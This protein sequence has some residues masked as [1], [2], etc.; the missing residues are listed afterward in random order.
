MAAR[1]LLAVVLALTATACTVS[2]SG[3]A[4]RPLTAVATTSAWGSILAQLGGDKVRTLS[5]ISNP[6]ADPHDYEPTPADARALA[7][8]RL[9]VENGVGYDAWA[10]RVLDA[11]PDSE[12]VVLNVGTLSGVNDDEN[13]HLWYSPADVDKLAG[14]VSDALV[15]IDPSEGDYFA[16]RR[17]AF[18]RQ[19]LARYHDLIADIRDRYA[20]VPI[21][22][23]ES[24]VSPLAN[25]LGLDLI[26]PHDFLTAI[27]EGIDPAAVDKRAVD[28]QIRDHRIKVYVFNRQN[29]TPDITAQVDAA[30]AAGIPVVAMTET[31]TPVGASFQDWQ[32]RQLDALRVA[33]HEATG[34]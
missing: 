13:P 9:V 18:D 22:A 11:S 26:T 34:R 4:P 17:D 2:P 7:V 3:G 12:R 28:E 29:S 23:S 10:R 16:R 6:N 8:A 27:S 33:L 30:R 5:L 32:V 19:A 14:A 1:A 21:G 31:L 15:R 25:A 24:I 20:G